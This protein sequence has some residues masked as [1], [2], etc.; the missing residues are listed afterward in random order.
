M[1]TKLILKS[2]GKIALW[3]CGQ[4]WQANIQIDIK[5]EGVWLCTLHSFGL[6]CVPVAGF[7]ERNNRP[8]D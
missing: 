4:K 7:Y 6:G 2:E 5:Q 8:L 3:R 1:N